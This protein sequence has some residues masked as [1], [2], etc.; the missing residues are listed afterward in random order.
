[1]TLYVVIGLIVWLL[2]VAL[3]LLFMHGGAG[4]RIWPFR[5]QGRQD[6]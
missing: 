4:S 5:R 3:L 2:L 6:D 1:M